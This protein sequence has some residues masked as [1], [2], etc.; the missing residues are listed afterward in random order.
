MGESV[1][2]FILVTG[3]TFSVQVQ[4]PTSETSSAEE[5]GQK[6]RTWLEQQYGPT[7]QAEL[8]S[9]SIDGRVFVATFQVTE[10]LT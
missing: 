1:P 7:V 6:A 10:E 5:A 8:T 2:K 4:V 3:R 9:L